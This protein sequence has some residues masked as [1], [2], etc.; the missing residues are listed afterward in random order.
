M[1]KKRVKGEVFEAH[2]S[3]TTTTSNMST[4]QASYKIGVTV[5]GQIYW[6]EWGWAVDASATAIEDCYG[7]CEI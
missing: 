3:Y 5:E 2:E 7:Y 4:L 6:S 1:S